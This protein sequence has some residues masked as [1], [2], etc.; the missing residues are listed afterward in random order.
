MHSIETSSRY[1]T[2]NDSMS[3]GTDGSLSLTHLRQDTEQALAAAGTLDSTLFTPNGPAGV[4]ALYV[5]S[6]TN[7]GQVFLNEFVCVSAEYS[8]RVSSYERSHTTPVS[9]AGLHDRIG[10][11]GGG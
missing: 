3:V 11:L 9:L 4:F 1:A 7:L 5:T 2:V 6:G 10:H 8:N